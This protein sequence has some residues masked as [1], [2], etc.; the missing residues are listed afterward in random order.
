MIL[1]YLRSVSPVITEDT[2]VAL[3][4]AGAACAGALMFWW[5]ALL[6][7][8][9]FFIAGMNEWHRRRT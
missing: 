5:L 3:T 7:L 6:A 1:D 4:M 8:P 2:V 9:F